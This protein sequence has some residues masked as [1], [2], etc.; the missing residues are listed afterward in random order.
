MSD[1]ENR[2]YMKGDPE[3]PTFAQA[4]VIL[5]LGAK[6]HD[7]VVDEQWVRNELADTSDDKYLALS[8]DNEVVDALVA[9]IN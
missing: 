9:Q 3:A 6:L 5:T 1:K 2:I 7:R 4:A 8:K